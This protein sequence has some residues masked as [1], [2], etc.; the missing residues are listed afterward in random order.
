MQISYRIVHIHNISWIVLRRL[1]SILHRFSNSTYLCH[2]KVLKK[3]FLVRLYWMEKFFKIVLAGYLP[4]NFRT[5]QQMSELTY[6]EF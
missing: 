5:F 4:P 2:M 3:W 6:A 1:K